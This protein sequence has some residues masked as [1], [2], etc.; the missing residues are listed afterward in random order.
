MEKVLGGGGSYNIE[1][2]LGSVGLKVNA[3][4]TLKVGLESSFHTAG[5]VVME[6]LLHV[7]GS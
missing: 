4:A 3:N 5:R 1:G 7:T 6:C 2:K